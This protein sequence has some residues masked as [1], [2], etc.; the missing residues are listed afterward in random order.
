MRIAYFTLRLSRQSGY[1][2]DE[3]N[4]RESLDTDGWLHTGD[5][6]KVDEMG[7]FK[8]IDRK[9]VRVSVAIVSSLPLQQNA[10][11]RFSFSPPRTS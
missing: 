4:T 10:Y 3:K 2:K 7:R 8:I 5:V 11:R 1:Y 9:K 6:C